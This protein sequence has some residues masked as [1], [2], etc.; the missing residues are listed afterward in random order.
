MNIDCQWIHNNLE[1]FFCE[2]LTGEENSLALRHIESCENCRKTVDEIRSVD[3]LIKK[4][5]RQELAAAHHPRR[6]RWSVP[7][8]I[9]ATAVAAV[10]A[11]VVMRTPQERPVVSPPIISSLPA[12]AAVTT[13]Q[14]EP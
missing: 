7:V 8:G 5:F 3:P 12:P 9:A 1:A 11:I 4:L 14:P 2:R 6:I 13:A 10:A